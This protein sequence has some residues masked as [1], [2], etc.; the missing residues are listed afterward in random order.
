MRDLSHKDFLFKRSK[1]QDHFGKGLSRTI[2]VAANFFGKAS[3]RPIFVNDEFQ[4]KFKD[5]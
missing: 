2:R 1:T 4:A 3:S 5:I